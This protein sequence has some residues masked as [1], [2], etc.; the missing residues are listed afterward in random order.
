MGTIL[1]LAT[2]FVVLFLSV[3]ATN[4]NE[5]KNAIVEFQLPCNNALCSENQV[6]ELIDQL[7]TI[8]GSSVSIIKIWKD[9][10]SLLICHYNEI[11]SLLN[12]IETNSVED[13]NFQGITIQKVQYTATLRASVLVSF[14]SFAVIT[15][16]KSLL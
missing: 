12:K 15:V 11:S 2:I 6:S 3:E 5:F 4:V 14:L 9:E 16:M 10:I 1:N 7:E 13:N 8:T